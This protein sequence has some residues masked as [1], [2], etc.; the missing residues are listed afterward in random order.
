MFFYR[1]FWVK[2][3]KVYLGGDIDKCMVESMCKCLVGGVFFQY[4]ISYVTEINAVCDVDCAVVFQSK[5]LYVVFDSH[6][7][8]NAFRPKRFYACV[9]CLETIVYLVTSLCLG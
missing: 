8:S 4:A 5:R 7:H 9:C 1:K 6:H 3:T 2:P